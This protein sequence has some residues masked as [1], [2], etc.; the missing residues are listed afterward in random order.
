M[1]IKSVYIKDSGPIE[2]CHIDLIDQWSGGVHDTMLITGYNGSGKTTVLNSVYALWM[3]AQYWAAY[4]TVKPANVPRFMRENSNTVMVLTGM[5]HFNNK[6]VVLF[7]GEESWVDEI[8][9]KHSGA[10]QIGEKYA[11]GP[12]SATRLFFFPEFLNRTKLSGLMPFCSGGMITHIL[13]GFRYHSG[14]CLFSN[15]IDSDYLPSTAGKIMNLNSELRLNH[16]NVKENVLQGLDSVLDLISPAAGIHKPLL[17]DRRLADVNTLSTLSHATLTVLNKVYI[18]LEK[19][20]P[21]SVVLM[22]DPTIELHPSAVSSILGKINHILR[23]KNCQLIIS[24]HNP[25]TVGK[26]EVT[27]GCHDLSAQ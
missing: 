11:I 13:T 1:K 10:V 15:Y 14:T 6:D 21:D 3:E 17:R 19:V 8:L 20:D 4:R 27:G 23:I 26:Y 22:E 2:N 12:D 9:K 16:K 24:A 7:H 18:L 25:I 5:K